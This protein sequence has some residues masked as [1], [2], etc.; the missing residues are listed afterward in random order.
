MQGESPLPGRV[1]YLRGA[2]AAHWQT[3][4]PTYAG[5]VYHGL[6][7]G[8]D[9][10]YG[11]AGGRLK[12]TYTLAP[13]ADPAL[14]RWRYEG[15]ESTTLDATGAL[16]ARIAG[17]EGAGATITEDAP[18]AWQEIDGQR[19]SVAAAYRLAADGSVG[20]ALGAYDA[21]RALTIDPVVNYATYLG[22]ASRDLARAIAVDATGAVYVTG[23]TDSLD[24]PVQG[25]FQPYYHVTDNVLSPRL[26]PVGH[27][28]GLRDV[29]RWRQL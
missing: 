16:V 8:I 15:I 24:F 1:N 26:Q 20:F 2:D 28:P 18:V 3:D 6:Y 4:L 5:L 21:G 27:G 14:I 10:R 11:G 7:A 29:P 25:P 17:G 23:V 13:G 19:V 9:S 12:G 22:G